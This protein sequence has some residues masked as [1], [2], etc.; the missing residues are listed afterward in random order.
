VR[1]MRR[2][3]V[4]RAETM[5]DAINR[6]VTSWFLRNWYAPPPPRLPQ[7]LHF[8]LHLGATLY[9][10]GLH[11][12]QHQAEL[13]RRRLPAF[14]I[15][16]GN[17][18]IGGTGKTPLTLW[19]SHHLRTLGRNPAIL[20]RGYKRRDASVAKVPSLGQSHREALRFGDEPAL[21]ARRA[22]PV[23]VWVGTDR[24]QS[25][26]LALQTDRVD[27]LILDDGFQ[28]LR[29]ERNLDLVLI[30]AHDPFGNGSLLPLGP[31]REPLAHLSRADAIV[32]TRAEDPEKTEETRAKI[33][34]WF[35]KKPV[36]SCIHRLTGLSI[37][38][39]GQHLPLAPFQGREAIAFAGIARPESFFY[40]LRKA[41]IIVSRCFAFPDH[42]PYQATDMAMLIE[43]MKE[44]KAPFL[45][46]T[47]KDMVR[48]SPEFQ[49]FA[50]ATLV[51]IDFLLD[52]QAFSSFLRARLSSR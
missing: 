14:V 10:T 46:T 52:Y 40:L 39:E 17:L 38:L 7:P 23:P 1:Q 21:M 28:H 26:S 45:I 30:D 42:H 32:L 13:R 8:L 49:A 11:R 3:R 27:T 25:G 6:T 31:L 22:A 15:S 51:E 34:Q 5:L 50:L 16:V 48:L 37:G 4:L 24:W 9:T 33:A 19:L 47:E 35:P 20:S 18:V 36:F 12:H 2:G 29:L 41:G 44:S 43:A